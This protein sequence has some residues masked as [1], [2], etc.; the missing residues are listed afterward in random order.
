MGRN[1]LFISDLQIPY[2]HHKAIDFLVR[3]KKEY[4]IKDEDVY[5]CG[6]E[7]DQYFGSL[8]K[9]NP[10]SKHSAVGEIEASLDVF[11]EL[12]LHFPLMKLA[13]SNHGTRWLRKATEAEIPSQ[14]IRK[15]EEII[16]AP[17]GWEW[18]KHWHIDTKKPIVL[19]HGDDHGGA[20]PHLQAALLY[21]KSAVMGHHHSKAGIEFVKT[22]G[23][24]A[25]GM[26]CGSL[27]DF[28]Q[29]AFDYARS[30]RYKPILSCGVV[31]DDG[32]IPVIIP[33]DEAAA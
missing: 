3:V 22:I 19:C 17:S 30:S 8:F 21:A 11:S 16:N 2:H 25:W 5:C 7:S 4:N 28:D 27:I 12:Y 32:R 26:V 6:D 18:R 10:N 15:Y 24:E 31:L 23:F 33:M 20:T 9:K 13:V 29:L 1:L 14:M